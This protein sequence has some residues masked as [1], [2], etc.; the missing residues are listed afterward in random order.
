[1]ARWYVDIIKEIVKTECD[2]SIS[3]L[4]CFHHPCNYYNMQKYK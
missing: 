2:D 1:M 3:S 4:F